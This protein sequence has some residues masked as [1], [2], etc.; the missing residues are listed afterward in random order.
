MSLYMK[1]Q[2]RSG[3]KAVFIL[4][5]KTGRKYVVSF[6]LQPDN[7]NR[8]MCISTVVWD[9]AKSLQSRTLKPAG[10]TGRW[11]ILCTFS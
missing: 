10:S 5:L 11:L 2:L 6:M 1:M 4:Y 7:L 9:L 3:N 8:G